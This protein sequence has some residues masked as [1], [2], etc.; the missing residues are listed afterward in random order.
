MF[1]FGNRITLIN[2]NYNTELSIELL[3]LKILYIFLSIF[4]IYL[5]FIEFKVT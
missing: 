2:L 5:H 1:K 4:N 3:L